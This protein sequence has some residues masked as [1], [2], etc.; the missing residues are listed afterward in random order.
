MGDIGR[1]R[2]GRGNEGISH[3]VWVLFHITGD[4][5][6]VVA[7][8]DLCR[9]AGCD[10]YGDRGEPGHLGDIDRLRRGRGNEG[11]S[12]IVWVLF[13]ITGDAHAVGLSSQ[14]LLSSSGAGTSDQ[15]LSSVLVSESSGKSGDKLRSDGEYALPRSML[16]PGIGALGSE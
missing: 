12:H 15:L 2:R 1:L 11:I 4:T 5:H 16:D 14:G 10:G 6:A 13:H 9:G 8:S 7:A 3:I